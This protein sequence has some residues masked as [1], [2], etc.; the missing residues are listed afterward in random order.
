M[1]GKRESLKLY[2]IWRYKLHKKKIL[3]TE[4]LI[5][6]LHVV[7]SDKAT[8]SSRKCDYQLAKKYLKDKIC[9]YDR[10]SKFGIQLNNQINQSH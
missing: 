5:S 9:F 10:E 1:N 6:N 3:I 7:V 2:N 4:K 8:D